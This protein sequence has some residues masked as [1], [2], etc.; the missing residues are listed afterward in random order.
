[1]IGIAGGPAKCAWI[2]DELGFDVA[3]DH[4]S[5]DVG[6]R[7]RLECPKG[8]DVYFD[9]VGGAIL[10]AALANLAARVWL[11]QRRSELGGPGNPIA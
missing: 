9:N 11:A 1:M 3:I 6:A 8:I 2:K 7:L 4:K 10:D 5:E